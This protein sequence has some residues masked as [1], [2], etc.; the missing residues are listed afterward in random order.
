MADHLERR[1]LLIARGVADP[2][3]ERYLQP[4]C[5]SCHGRK[6]FNERQSGPR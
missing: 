3:A 1:E 4:L 5:Q 2:D 6:S